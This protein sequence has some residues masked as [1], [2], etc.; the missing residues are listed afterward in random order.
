M[1]TTSQEY[2]ANLDILQNV[3]QPA[4]ALLPSAEN[5]LKI[6]INTRTVEA[7]EFLSVEKDHKSET[8]YFEVNRKAG[9]V[10]LAETSCVI[11]YNNADKNTGTRYYAVP[12][13]DIT[14]KYGKIIFPWALDGNVSLM[15]GI[16][17]FSIQFFK[18]DTIVRED[19]AKKVVSYSLNTLPAYSKVLN[20]IKE[21]QLDSDDEYYLM[22]DQY[23]ELNNRI[24]TL[25]QTQKLYWTILDDSFAGS[26]IDNSQ[27][28]DTIIDILE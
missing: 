20:G 28:Q 16:V 19:T 17:E 18:I 15:S 26:P 21:Q 9:Y 4:Y 5:I 24:D 11:I 10:D 1:I 2:F 14:T 23:K 8:I 7:P 3:N 22:P 25:Q 13:Y 12:Y 6:D 27:V